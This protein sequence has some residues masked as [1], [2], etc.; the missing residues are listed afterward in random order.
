M[1]SG[2]NIMIKLE[3]QP[4]VTFTGHA[5]QKKKGLQPFIRLLMW[6]GMEHSWDAYL[7]SY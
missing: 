3:K 2:L 7:R 6:N 1:L 4:Q 5:L